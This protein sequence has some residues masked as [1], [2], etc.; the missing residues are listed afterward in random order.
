MTFIKNCFLLI[1][2]HLLLVVICYLTKTVK[3]HS[4]NSLYPSLLY[5]PIKHCLPTICFFSQVRSILLCLLWCCSTPSSSLSL[6]Y[7]FTQC[8]SCPPCDVGAVSVLCIT[9]NILLISL[10]FYCIPVLVNCPC[11]RTLRAISTCFWPLV[12]NCNSWWRLILIH[13]QTALLVLVCASFHPCLPCISLAALLPICLM[14]EVVLK[15][16]RVSHPPFLPSGIYSWQALSSWYSFLYLG[17][18]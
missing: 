16:F 7:T 9:S 8:Y 17:Y 3:R 6:V 14:H 15:S 12:L 18:L 5:S 2:F 10:V 13:R 4:L 11:H 1:V